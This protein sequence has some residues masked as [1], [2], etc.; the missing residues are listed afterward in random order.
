MPLCPLPRRK[1]ERILSQELSFDSDLQAQ[2]RSMASV[3]ELCCLVELSHLGEKS[4]EVEFV[5]D[6]ND[7]EK[8]NVVEDSRPHSEEK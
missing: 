3:E 6:E 2:A 7:E 8:E 1:F 4:P 5:E